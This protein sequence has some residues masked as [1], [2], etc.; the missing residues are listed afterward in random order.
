MNTEHWLQPDLSPLV[1]VPPT[2]AAAHHHAVAQPHRGVAVPGLG[3]V[4]QLAGGAGAHHLH[5]AQ[6]Y[7]SIP[8]V[9]V[10]SSTWMWCYWTKS[11]EYHSMAGAW[12][13]YVAAPTVTKLNFVIVK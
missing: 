9:V 13:C 7:V 11:H 2:E 4:G 8:G 10:V 3:Q 5:W 1:D 12:D 6:L